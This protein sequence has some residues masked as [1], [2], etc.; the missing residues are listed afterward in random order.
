MNNYW[1][2]SNVDFYNLLCPVKVEKYEN[3]HSQ[4][5]KKEDIIYFEKQVNKK[6]YLV[7]KGKVKLVN[8]DE[9]GNEIFQHIV[10]QGELFGENAVL[11][12]YQHNEFAV[13]ADNNTNV[14]SINTDTLQQLMMENKDFSTTIFRY[15][16]FRRRKIS[17]RLELLI[18]KDVNARVTAY[19]FDLYKETEKIN[20][21][22]RL[23]QAEIGKLL[24]TSRE[25]VARVFNNLKDKG[26]IDYS[27]KTIFIKDLS[28]LIQMSQ[29]NL[30]NNTN[31]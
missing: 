2:L 21:K 29:M 6:I 23:T 18:G 7:S 22:N 20:I 14:C 11:G 13:A 28:G 4:I 25:S 3:K 27:R 19:I 8:Y 5:Y 16:A 15:I 9:Q 30:S 31:F 17:R 1:C 12:D 10:L 24:A 26:V